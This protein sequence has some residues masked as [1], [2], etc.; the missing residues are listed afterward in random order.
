MQ[1]IRAIPSS[2]GLS[3]RTGGTPART[4]RRSYGNARPHCESSRPP[5]GLCRAWALATET[6]PAVPVP[7]SGHYRKPHR[8]ARAVSRGDRGTGQETRP[9]VV[10]PP[11][12]AARPRFDSHHWHWL[13]SRLLLTAWRARH[14]LNATPS[15][16][17]RDPRGWGL[18]ARPFFCRLLRTIEQHLIPIDPLQS[19]IALGQLRPRPAKGILLQPPRE[20]ALDGFVGRKAGRQHPPPDSRYQNIEH[21]VQTLPVVIGRTPSGTLRC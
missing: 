19:F 2:D 16:I 12:P 14:R 17:C 9:Q 5:V 20:P 11:R 18:F 8:L 15:R 7:G 21:G 1:P 3:D 13:R 10:A 4:A 6:L